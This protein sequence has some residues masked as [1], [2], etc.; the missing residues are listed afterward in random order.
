M[1]ETVS[2]SN[3]LQVA[4][5]IGEKGSKIREL[6]SVTHCSCQCS[7]KNETPAFELCGCKREIEAAKE[8]IEKE[9][10]QFNQLN[11]QF[12]LPDLGIPLLLNHQGRELQRIENETHT[13]LIINKEENYVL[14]RGKQSSYV[15]QAKNV[16]T[17]LFNSISSHEYFI[18]NEI[19]N[20]FI[21][22]KGEHINS[23]RRQFHVSIQFNE[24]QLKCEGVNP[25]LSSCNEY[26][27]KWF[28][29]HTVEYLQQSKDIVGRVIVGKQGQIIQSLEKEYHLRIQQKTQ[30]DYTTLAFIGKEEDVKSCLL[31]VRQ[32]IEGFLST[33][34]SIQF[35]LDEWN[36]CSSLTRSSISS[37]QHLYSQ[38]TITVI[39]STGKITCEGP[40]AD[41]AQIKEVFETIKKENEDKKV[42]TYSLK[43]QYAGIIIGKNGKTIHDLEEQY[44]VVMKLQQEKE[45]LFLWCS[46]TQWNT[47]QS[48]LNSLIEEKAIITKTLDI[49][50]TQ[51]KN[52]LVDKCKP[53]QAIQ[54]SF[55]VTITLPAR[56]EK[57]LT[58]S[59][60]RG[61]CEKAI[62]SIQSIIKGIYTY[63]Y[64]YNAT[65]LQT[66]IQLPTFHIERIALANHCNIQYDS[67]GNVDIRGSYESIHH[68][69]SLLYSQ[70]TLL[71]PYQ[72]KQISL[73]SGVVYYLINNKH[74]LSIDTPLCTIH[75]EPAEKMIYIFGNPSQVEIK[76]NEYCYKIALLE[77]EHVIISFE[78]ELYSTIVGLKGQYV[79]A[80]EK[81][82]QVKC[83]L[84]RNSNEV[85]LEGEKDAVKTVEEILVNKVKEQKE[86]YSIISTT[87]ALLTCFIEEYGDLVK[88][89]EKENQCELKVDEKNHCLS[90]YGDDKENVG[91]MRFIVEN[92]LET[93]EIDQEKNAFVVEESDIQDEDHT[94]HE[95]LQDHQDHQD[96]ESQDSSDAK[97]QIDLL[98]GL[99]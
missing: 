49:E 64:H 40:P 50:F 55:N 1:K 31:S 37:L 90:I 71:F 8:W 24:G 43:K 29:N 56:N 13:R 88:E 53:I 21:G 18:P 32:K 86:R 35:S 15:E 77:T 85:Y 51:Q 93:I 79:K 28:K 5:L 96:N 65:C 6:T 66:L 39:A 4:Y 83:I 81:E 63:H 99:V 60:N 57:T 46:E 97:Q 36:W 54:S 12:N 62:Q 30:D 92:M 82:Y 27:I 48:V 22:K 19:R 23:L 72:F 38:S 69:H 2:L 16:L 17:T 10:I 67:R 76:Y 61:N 91:S 26:L 44:H 33:H 7:N 98:L 73:S 68:S 78:K 47:I 84:L 25:N 34:Y 59:G 3:T 14:I 87:P 11:F 95:D 20:E 58:I 94:E 42:F 89:W 9:L 41:I 74:S 80:L 70:L 45:T 52:L 75:V